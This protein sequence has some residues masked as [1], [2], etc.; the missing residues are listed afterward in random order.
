MKKQMAKRKTFERKSK[1][2]IRTRSNKYIMA[3]M[4]PV[5]HV[6]MIRKALITSGERWS[7][8]TPTSPLNPRIRQNRMNTVW[9]SHRYLLS[10]MNRIR[11]L[12]KRAILVLCCCIGQNYSI[13]SVPGFFYTNR[14]SYYTKRVF[15]CHHFFSTCTRQ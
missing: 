11:G 9:R 3:M 10:A 12:L 7:L 13:S 6:S 1:R 15:V 14:A 4:D 5:V 2:G 8:E